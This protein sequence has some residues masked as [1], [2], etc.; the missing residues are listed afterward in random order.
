MNIKE[1]D[2]KDLYQDKELKEGPYNKELIFDEE[3]YLKINKKRD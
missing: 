2:N 1:T 3:Q